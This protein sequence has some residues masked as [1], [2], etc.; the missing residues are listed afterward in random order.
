M[1]I[2]KT[3]WP[4]PGSQRTKVMQFMIMFTNRQR[5]WWCLDAAQA[6]KH[7]RFPLLMHFSDEYITAD[8]VAA[9][10]KI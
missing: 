6:E 3:Q 9:S 7:H 10:K 8:K 2:R 5:A 4:L 1:L